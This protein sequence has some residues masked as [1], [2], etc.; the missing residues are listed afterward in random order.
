VEGIDTVARKNRRLAS[1]P[2]EDS[3]IG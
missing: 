3:S 1:L 2:V